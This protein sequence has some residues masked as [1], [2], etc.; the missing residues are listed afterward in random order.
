MVDVCCFHE[1]IVLMESNLNSSSSP[2]LEVAVISLAGLGLFT[3]VLLSEEISGS[4]SHILLSSDSSLSMKI[5]GSRSEE[6]M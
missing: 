3:G 1:L 5:G 6:Q 4:L 2:P